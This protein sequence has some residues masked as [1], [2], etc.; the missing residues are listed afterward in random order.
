MLLI[1]KPEQGV[2]SWMRGVRKRFIYFSLM[3]SWSLSVFIML[4]MNELLLP[5]SSR[6][7]LYF[8]YSLGNPV[9]F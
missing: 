1:D 7:Y 3:G 9:E 4:K 5:S 6:R 2:Y 8:S